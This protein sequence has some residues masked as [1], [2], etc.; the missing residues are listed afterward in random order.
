MGFEIGIRALVCGCTCCGGQVVPEVD[1]DKSRCV[2]ATCQCT[3]VNCTDSREV[4]TARVAPGRSRQS[5]NRHIDDLLYVRRGLGVT[6]PRGYHGSTD[7][8]RT[9]SANAQ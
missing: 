8:F 6:D 3:C 5:R 7:Y 2:G 4:Q 9:T 1:G